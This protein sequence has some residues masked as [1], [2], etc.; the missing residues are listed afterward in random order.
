MEYNGNECTH[1]LRTTII[2]VGVLWHLWHSACACFMFYHLRYF[3]SFFPQSRVHRMMLNFVVKWAYDCC[4]A[5]EAQLLLDV[6]ALGI[7]LI[8]WLMTVHVAAP[9]PD[10]PMAV[11]RILL[12]DLV[13][14]L[15]NSRSIYHPG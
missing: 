2:T 5:A 11:I 8:Y 6:S 1:S 7:W 15:V 3:P 12:V 4:L 9:T 13:L 14:C 10:G